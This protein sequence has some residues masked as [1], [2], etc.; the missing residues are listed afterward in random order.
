MSRMFGWRKH[1][2]GLVSHLSGTTHRS[3]D[4]VIMSKYRFLGFHTG[5]QNDGVTGTATSFV[6][7]V[8]CE[9]NRC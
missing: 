9:V 8:A 6:K 5:K 7:L 4:R 3:E 1:L 2:L